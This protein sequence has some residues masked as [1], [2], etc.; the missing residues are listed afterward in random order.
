[1]NSLG[2][3]CADLAVPN[4]FFFFFLFLFQFDD[5]IRV[6]GIYYIY[7]EAGAVRGGVLEVAFYF[8]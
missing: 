2:D 7:L 1:M 4:L 5:G 8:G 3:F 6:S